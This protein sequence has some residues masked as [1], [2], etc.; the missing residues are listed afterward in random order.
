MAP[1]LCAQSAESYVLRALCLKC[2]LV[3][4]PCLGG[5]TTSSDLDNCS[6]LLLG[7][8][9]PSSALQSFLIH[10]WVSTRGR[11]LDFVPQ[12]TFGKVWRHFWLFHL[13]GGGGGYYWQL[14]GEI[15]DAGE[16]R[17]VQRIAHNKESSGPDVS[18]A[19]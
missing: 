11:G 12:G 3:S 8:L 13:R 10:Q 14:M 6:S 2:H 5:A 15:R 1:L 4:A 16:H 9:S 19:W 17:T 18:S 7:L